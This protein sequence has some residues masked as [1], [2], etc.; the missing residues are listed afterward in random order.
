MIVNFDVN[1]RFLLKIAR[2]HVSIIG[3]IHQTL[4]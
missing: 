4:L 1:V 3:R 2:V